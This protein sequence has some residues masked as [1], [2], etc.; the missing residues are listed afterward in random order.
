MT[1]REYMSAALALAER[2]RGYTSPNPRV[3]AILVRDGVVVGQGFHDR[4]G[5]KHAEVAALAEARERARGATLFVTLEPCSV[6]GKTP[7]CTE[8]IIAAGITRVVVPIEDPNPDIAGRGL[9]ALREAGMDVELGLLRSDATHLNAPYLKFRRVGLPH[10]HLKLAVS[11]D[12]RVSARDGSALSIS[13]DE[14]RARVHQL[15]SQVDAVLVGI[16]TV[17]SDD[18]RLTDR[19]PEGGKRQPAR[20]VI[21]ST[22][23]MSDAAA[24]AIGA[25]EHRT[26]I[27]AGSGADT[28]ARRRLERAGVEIWTAGAGDG[29]LDLEEALRHAASE[30]LIDILCEGGPRLATSLLNARLV[31]RVSFFVGPSLIGSPAPAALGGIRLDDLVVSEGQWSILGS[32]ALF[33]A[34]ITHE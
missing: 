10:V 2:G 4:F 3:G 17:L 22:L 28:E 23:R 19:R 14:S 5:G 9:A 20:I 12:G 13:S 21:D 8:A 1:D 25:R 15:R 33:E 26:I 32:D 30:G 31:D 6:W 7:P 16:G 24:L 27:V 29:G 11:L 18:P 34:V